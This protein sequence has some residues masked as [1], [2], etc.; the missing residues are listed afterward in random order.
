M[1]TFYKNEIGRVIRQSTGLDWSDAV[2]KTITIVYP[3]ST[4]YTK[5][6]T[7]VVIDDAATGQIH[8][9]SGTH[10][11]SVNDLSQTGRYL[12]QANFIDSASNKLYGP[13]T[14]FEVEEILA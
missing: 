9:L 2:T 5:T 8:F 14:T 11:S 7:A 13:W 10:G 6:A 3:D 12:M 1:E 4:S